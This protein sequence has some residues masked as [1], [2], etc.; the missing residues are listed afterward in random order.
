MKSIIDGTVKQFRFRIAPHPF[1]SGEY[2]GTYY[3]FYNDQV[4][5]AFF[6]DSMGYELKDVPRKKVLKDEKVT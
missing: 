3:K 4:A 2:P 6:K 5:S 1:M